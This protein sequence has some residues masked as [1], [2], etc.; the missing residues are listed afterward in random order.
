[1]TLSALPPEILS[2]ICRFI[3]AEGNSDS[4]IEEESSDFSVE[5]ESSDFSVEEDDLSDCTLPQDL[6]SLRLSCREIYQKTLFDVGIVYGQMLDELVVDLSY[7]SLGVLFSISCVP[8]FRDQLHKITF[9][10]PYSSVSYLTSTYIWDLDD[11][12]DSGH[13]E[14]RTA[15][16]N[17]SETLHI[18]IESFKNLA[19]STSLLK[20]QVREETAYPAVIKALNLASFPR[21]ILHVVAEPKNLHG[22]SHDEF[23]NPLSESPHLISHMEIKASSFMDFE[24]LNPEERE[25]EVEANETGCHY[26]SYR[27]VTPSLSNLAAKLSG[28]ETITYYGC[29]SSP[30]LRLCHGCEDIWV[31]L[32]AKNTYAHL[33]NLELYY[34]YVSG[35]RLRGFIKRHAGTLQH[36]KFDCMSLTDGNWRSIAQG[37]QKCPDLNYLNVGED[38]AMGGWVGSLRQRHAPQP[39]EV[40][41]PEKYATSGFV[42]RKN[43][44]SDDAKDIAIILRNKKDVAHW[45]DVFVR[46]FAV[47]EDYLGGYHLPGDP[48][49]PRYYEAR[50]FFLPNHVTE[51]P[52]PRSRAQIALDRYLEEVEEA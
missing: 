39:L 34:G 52:D 49:L 42:I 17:S 41:L 15:F 11:S 40:S 50:T 22:H 30:R 1:M 27:S 14:E 47:D 25:W 24:E 18:L 48:D 9:T 26:S 4:S 7:K 20:I 5:E 16:A 46:Y 23:W 37:L 8:Y 38:T 28:V 13:C 21:R 45:L 36:V 10:G 3:L 12:E 29:N 2:R 32:F 31:S 35:S 44:Q 43:L 33:T 6:K 51:I 19:R